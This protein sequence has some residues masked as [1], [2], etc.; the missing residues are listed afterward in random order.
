MTAGASCTYL[1]GYYPVTGG[2]HT[3]ALMITDNNLNA[4]LP[5]GTTQSLV[6][7]G[8]MAQ[9]AQTITSPSPGSTLTGTDVTFTWTSGV[10]VTEYWLYIG[11]GYAGSTNLYNASATTNSATVTNLP[12]IGEILYVRL[13]TKIGGVWLYSDYT[14][15]EAGRTALAVM[16]SPTPGS[17][18]TGTSATFAWGDVGATEYWLN[19]GTGHAGANNLY[20][21]SVA[22]SIFVDSATVTGLPHL[23]RQFTSASSPR[24]TASGSTTTTP[25]PRRERLLRR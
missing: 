13:L 20:N 3:G 15:T 11:T 23:A 7:N 21:A 9:S 18:L 17:A 14:Y 10:G 24:S 8:G 6:L 5:A 12:S 16:N 4:A 2:A 1:V 25:T 19:V 22:H